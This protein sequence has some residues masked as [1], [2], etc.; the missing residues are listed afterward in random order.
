MCVREN[1]RWQQK[2]K[3]KVQQTETE[4]VL[5]HVNKEVWFG[6]NVKESECRKGLWCFPTKTK[7]FLKKGIDEWVW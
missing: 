2:T 4:V 6:R 7:T 5:H 1:K 3:E